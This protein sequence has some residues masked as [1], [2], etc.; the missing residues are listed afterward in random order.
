MNKK[1]L[2]EYAES[3]MK[4]KGK[5]KSLDALTVAYIEKMKKLEADKA[6]T[7]TAS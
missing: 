2:K 5:S 6:S 3:F 7:T 1:N 4:S